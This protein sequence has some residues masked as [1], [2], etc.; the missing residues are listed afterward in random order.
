[1]SLRWTRG[2]S[3]GHSRYT[4]T[5]DLSVG[6]YPFTPGVSPTLLSLWMEVR[7]AEDRTEEGWRLCVSITTNR[8]PETLEASF[9][10]SSFY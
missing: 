2:H 6:K 3:R 4:Q 7:K 10:G 5:T 9:W 8:T 1:M